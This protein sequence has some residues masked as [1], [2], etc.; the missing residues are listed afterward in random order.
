MVIGNQQPA[1]LRPL[2]RLGAKGIATTLTALERFMRQGIHPA[3]YMAYSRNLDGPG[4]KRLADARRLAEGIKHWV[5]TEVLYPD[6]V[7]RRRKN[8]KLFLEVAGV[9]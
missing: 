1:D 3:D 6:E 4:A 8:L 9:S 2:R 7:A 5:L